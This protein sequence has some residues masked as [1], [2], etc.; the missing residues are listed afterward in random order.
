MEIMSLSGRATRL[1]WWLAKIGGVILSG[2]VGGLALCLAQRMGLCEKYGAWVAIAIVGAVI[3]VYLWMTFAVTIRRLHDRGRSGWFI[4]VYWL[5]S[6]IPFV[7]LAYLIDLGFMDGIM[8]P[9]KYGNDPKGR[10]SPCHSIPIVVN[11]TQNDVRASSEHVK[12]CS[13]CG[14]KLDDDSRFCS[15]CG[16]PVIGF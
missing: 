11:V 3:L 12:F 13:N 14:A 1:E 9:N 2:F 10:T 4:L 5:L 16:K 6:A 7:W 8:G 15:C